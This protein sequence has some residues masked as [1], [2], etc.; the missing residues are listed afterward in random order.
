MSKTNPKPNEDHIIAIQHLLAGEYKQGFKL[1]DKLK[2]ESRD[3]V[4]YQASLL[5]YYNPGLQV[6]SCNYIPGHTFTEEQYVA[7]LRGLFSARPSLFGA[8]TVRSALYTRSPLCFTLYAH[9]IRQA[10]SA[11]LSEHCATCVCESDSSTV[12]RIRQAFP[13][14]SGNF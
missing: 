11:A 13:A 3:I 14:R 4:H 6:Y 8:F 12:R 10:G 9:T 5:L 2:P 1:F 7:H